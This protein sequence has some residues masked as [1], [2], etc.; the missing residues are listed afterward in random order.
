MNLQSISVLMGQI[1]APIV[2]PSAELATES[3]SCAV[4]GQAPSTHSES[5]VAHTVLQSASRAPTTWD[6]VAH[7]KFNVTTMR[8][9]MHVVLICINDA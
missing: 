9:Q 5:M 2:A 6:E 4:F 3:H 1:G 8:T 7:P